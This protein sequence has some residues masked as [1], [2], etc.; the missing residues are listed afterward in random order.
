MKGTMGVT[1]LG[2][3]LSQILK[4]TFKAKLSSIFICE[5]CITMSY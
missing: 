3:L 2:K 5:V 1:V 4:L